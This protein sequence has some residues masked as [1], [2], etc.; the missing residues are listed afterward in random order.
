MTR[1]LLRI[2]DVKITKMQ[3]SV[4]D[5]LGT[6]ELLERII[7]RLGSIQ[8][9]IRAQ[10]VCRRWRDV[11]QDSPAF[12]QACWYRSH[13]KDESRVQKNPATWKLNPVFNSLRVSIGRNRPG[14][15]PGDLH[16]HGDFDLTKRVYDKPGSWTTM[17]ATQ[18][19]CRR[20][21]VECYGDYSGDEIM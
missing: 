9:I 11:I 7:L 8:D 13:G 14:L 15:L 16:E 20:M 10:L 1:R 4:K 3:S 12:Q 5:V 18:P 2:T 17:L 21:E 19:P 6:Y